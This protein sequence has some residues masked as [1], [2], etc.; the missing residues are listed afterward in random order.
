MITDFS[1]IESLM[2]EIDSVL[3]NKIHIFTIG[4]AVLLYRGLKDAT[5]D[6]DLI[7]NSHDEF[8]LLKNTLKQLGFQTKRPGNTYSRMNLSEIF[9]RDKLR[10]DLFKTQVCGGFSLT[11]TMVVR[12]HKVI[13]LEKITMYLCS[14]EDVFLFKTMTEREGDLTDCLNI[15]TR[16]LEWELILQELNDQIDQS[17]QD[18]WITW[19]GER[20]DLL[21]ERGL[22]IPI[23]AK[24]DKLREEFFKKYE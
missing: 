20:I 24:I 14:N 22:E 1:N 9:Q 23:K 21:E 10:I 16:D 6:V 18:V 3:N 13:E 4:G 5:K 19:V 11:E 2:K 8:F 15:S 12:A 7:V 17:K